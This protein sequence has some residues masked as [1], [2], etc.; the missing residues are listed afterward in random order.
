MENP[1]LSKS[2]KKAL[3][4]DYFKALAKQTETVA[5]LS[6]LDKQLQNIDAI[7]DGVTQMLGYVPTKGE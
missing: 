3:E 2:V 4:K 1:T 5:K 6:I 7:M